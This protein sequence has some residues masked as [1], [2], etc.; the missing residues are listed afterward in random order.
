MY[1]K[2]KLCLTHLLVAFSIEKESK[3]PTF[4]FF[5]LFYGTSKLFVQYFWCVG[6]HLVANVTEKSHVK[7][8]ILLLPN[9]TSYIGVADNFFGAKSWKLY[10]LPL[11]FFFKDKIREY[12][13]FSNYILKTLLYFAQYLCTF[14]AKQGIIYLLLFPHRRLNCRFSYNWDRLIHSLPKQYCQFFLLTCS[15]QLPKHPSKGYSCY[16][17]NLCWMF[18]SVLNTEYFIH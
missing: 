10:F 2:N 9:F 7:C 15:C 14:S 12:L 11:I 5:L 17:K 1:W 6:H 8:W 4:L 3:R 13:I 18:H 16:R